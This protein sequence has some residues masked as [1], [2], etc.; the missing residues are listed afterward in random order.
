META[1]GVWL[2]IEMLVGANHRRKARHSKLKGHVTIHHD[3]VVITQA[4]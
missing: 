4:Q 1:G 2:E 3:P